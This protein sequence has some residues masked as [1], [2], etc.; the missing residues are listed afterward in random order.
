[1][2]QK[3]PNPEKE[4]LDKIMECRELL[5]KISHRPAQ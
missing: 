3:N 2:E 5:K 4:L 1:M